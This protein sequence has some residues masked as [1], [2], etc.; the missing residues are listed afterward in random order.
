[1]SRLGAINSR[2]LTD[3]RQSCVRELDI[4]RHI[5]G[6]LDLNVKPYSTIGVES[7]NFLQKNSQIIR[8]TDRNKSFNSNK[9]L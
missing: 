4:Q 5:Q 9:H 1:M 7:K 6:Q 8:D 2:F 3:Y